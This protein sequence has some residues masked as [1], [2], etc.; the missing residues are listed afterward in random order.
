MSFHN[1]H[2]DNCPV[3]ILDG[4]VVTFETCTFSA[5]RKAHRQSHPSYAVFAHG[6]GTCVSINNCRFEHSKHH[7][8]ACVV[9]KGARMHLDQCKLHAFRKAS[10]RASGAHCRVSLH[11]CAIDS[12]PMN[13]DGMLAI[14]NMPYRGVSVCQGAHG[15]LWGCMINDILTGVCVVNATARVHD[16]QIEEPEHVCLAVHSSSSVTCEGCRFMSALDEDYG[17]GVM[18]SG[19]STLKLNGC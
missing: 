11:R 13:V 15:M 19:G 5:T 16:T 18:V 4:A 14:S 9:Q 1:V 17:H 2:F 10:V 12:G 7:S 8:E 6:K 3:I